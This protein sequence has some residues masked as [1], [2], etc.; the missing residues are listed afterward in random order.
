MYTT[1]NVNDVI[2]ELHNMK[3]F[4]FRNEMFKPKYAQPV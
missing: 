1:F 2:S 4:S 3:E